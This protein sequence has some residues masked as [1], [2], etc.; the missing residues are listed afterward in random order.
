ME[1]IPQAPAHGQPA[2]PTSAPYPGEERG[3]IPQPAPPA[4]VQVAPVREQL[5]AL[6]RA[7]RQGYGGAFQ[8]VVS[9]ADLNREIAASG[10]GAVR[11][12][13]VAILDGEVAA[14]GI[15]DMG[16]TPV[17]VLLRGQPTMEGSRPRLLIKQAYLGRMPAPGSLVARVQAELDRT[18]QKALADSSG[19]TVTGISARRGMIII[20]GYLA[21]GAK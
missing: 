9:E 1:T 11:N 14:I 5:R 20:E 10:E 3:E 4:A 6:E 12:V 16:P 13:A 2:S 15:V 18:V 19:A 8:I 21:G 7:R 17:Q